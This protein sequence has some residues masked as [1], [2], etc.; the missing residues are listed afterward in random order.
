MSDV[1]VGV[2]SADRDVVTLSRATTW[3]K[4][5]GIR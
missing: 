5:T 3:P 4:I 2:T 1:P